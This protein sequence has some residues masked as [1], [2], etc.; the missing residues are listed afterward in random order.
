LSEHEAIIES[1][2]TPR[3]LPP[4]VRV[5]V[6]PK[7]PRKCTVHAEEAL[8]SRCSASPDKAHQPHLLSPPS[9]PIHRRIAEVAVISHHSAFIMFRTALRTSSRAA[10][11]VAASS[12]I[13]AVCTPLRLAAGAPRVQVHSPPDRRRQQSSMA[14][15]ITWDAHGMHW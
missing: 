6:S 12:R 9:S 4:D 7:S 8:S 15:T 3:R 5:S 1:P 2:P 14:A 10:G 13:S 11:A